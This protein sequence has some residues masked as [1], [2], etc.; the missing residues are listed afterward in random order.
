MT[1]LD[2]RISDQLAVEDFWV[3]DEA[4]RSVYG[5]KTPLVRTVT[6]KQTD[7]P[8]A[9]WPDFTIV[10]LT[11]QSHWT[12]PADIWVSPHYPFNHH[13][14]ISTMVHELAHAYIGVQYQHEEP[15][16]NL[17][18]SAFDKLAGWGWRRDAVLLMK[19][20]QMRLHEEGKMK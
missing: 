19:K 18:C 20:G 5:F 2:Y 6:S 3:L 10:G 8:Y 13:E 9:V 11:N 4:V 14:L 16:V 12:S 1:T 15:W 17:M 7:L